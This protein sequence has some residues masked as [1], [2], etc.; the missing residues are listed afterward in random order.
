MRF[1]V[2]VLGILSALPALA[3]DP[4][5]YRPFGRYIN[6]PAY[7]NEVGRNIALLE[8]HLAPDCIQVL[9]GM[10]RMEVRIVQQPIFLPGLPI[11]QGG[12]WREQLQ[13]DRCGEDA[14]HN[15]LVTAANGSTPFMT[16]L[17]PG[18]S[19]ADGRLQLNASPATFAIAGVRAGKGCESEDRKIINTRFLDWLDGTDKSPLGERKWR[20][21]WTVRL[22][23]RSV[24]VQIDFLP[25]GKGG[26]THAANLPQSRP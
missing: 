24:D 22:C 2:A 26:Y 6:S 5:W 25:D 8:Q 10:E 21:I 9:Q 17:L 11:P 15:V 7:L 12:Q 16:V 3:A 18:T 4:D 13:I 23:D 19:K 1:L 14:V 20:E